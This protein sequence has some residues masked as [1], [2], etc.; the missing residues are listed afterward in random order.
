MHTAHVIY[1]I[2]E[3]KLIKEVICITDEPKNKK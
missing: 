1:A 2:V 3:Q